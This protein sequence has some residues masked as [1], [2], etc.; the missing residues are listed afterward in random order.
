MQVLC[1]LILPIKVRPYNMLSNQVSAV[2]SIFTDNLKQNK[3]YTGYHYNLRFKSRGSFILVGLWCLM[4]VVLANGYG[5]VLFSFLSVAK[6]EQPINTLVELAN[7]KEVQLSLVLGSETARNFMVQ[8]IPYTV[9]VTNWYIACY[10]YFYFI[11]FTL[12]YVGG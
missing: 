7:S 1:Y 11:N 2:L 4:C 8:F 9:I 5:G 3:F 10:C 6:L 12:I